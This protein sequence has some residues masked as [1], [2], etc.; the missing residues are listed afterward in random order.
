MNKN[1]QIWHSSQLWPQTNYG[2]DS[3]T[4]TT[5]NSVSLQEL[6][7][8]VDASLESVK[9]ESKSELAFLVNCEYT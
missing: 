2:D 8:K 7:E 1:F 5:V 9:S 4:V 6:N 3:Q